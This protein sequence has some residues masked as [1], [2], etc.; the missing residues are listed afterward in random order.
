MKLKKRL[1]LSLLVAGAIVLHI[2][3]AMLP[4]FLVI[5]GAKLGLA[6]II[7]LFVLLYFGFKSAFLVITLRIFLSSLL[8][9]TFFS[10]SFFLSLTGGLLS[11]LVMGFAYYFY[12]HK[13]S[14]IGISVLGAAFHNFGQVS[15]ASVI[16]DNW[17][18]ILYLPYLLLLSLPTG[19]FVGL[20]VIK[21]SNYLEFDLVKKQKL[22][23]N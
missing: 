19:V 5:P 10:I 14:I 9:G 15:M 2:V 6:N 23:G 12:S 20:V 13:F 18:L 4:T 1:T 7:T 11:L 17:R 8:I 21:L 16:I 22:E 3:E